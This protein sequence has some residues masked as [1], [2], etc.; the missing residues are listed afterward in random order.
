MPHDDVVKDTIVATVREVLAA[1]GLRPALSAE[2][3]V[4]RSLG[5]DSL[6]WAAVVVQ[7]E[8]RLGLDPFAE[9][10]MPSLVTL[11]DFIAFYQAHAQQG[12]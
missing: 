11:G 8:D 12:R 6:D 10:G 1:K 4:D 9:G 2:S 7:L 5:L 3:P